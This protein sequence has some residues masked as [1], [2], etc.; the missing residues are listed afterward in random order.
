MRWFDKIVRLEDIKWLERLVRHNL[1]VGVVPTLIRRSILA[2]RERVKFFITMAVRNTVGVTET[3]TA[4]IRIVRWVVNINELLSVTEKITQFITNKVSSLLGIVERW[5][6]FATHS[7]VPPCD[8]V[9]LLDRS[10]NQLQYDP[11]PL[12][13]SNVN[14]ALTLLYD[15]SDPTKPFRI[16]F[17][18]NNPQQITHVSI[19][20]TDA[21]SNARFILERWEGGTTYTVLRTI[22]LNNQKGWLTH[23]IPDDYKNNVTNLCIRAVGGADNFI[24]IAEVRFYTAYNFFWQ[25]G[26]EWIK[27]KE[28]A[29]ALLNGVLSLFPKNIVNIVETVSAT[30]TYSGNYILA[31]VSDLVT[32]VENLLL[33]I[34][35][36]FKDTVAVTET[37]DATLLSGGGNLQWDYSVAYDQNG[38][39]ISLDL[40]PLQDSNTSTSVSIYYTPSVPSNPRRFKVGWNNP[41][42]FYEIS[43]HV[44]GY[45][46]N[47]QVVITVWD[48][49]GS[50]YTEAISITGT[51]W[52]SHYI[53]YDMVANVKEVQFAPDTNVTGYIA[54]SEVWFNE[55]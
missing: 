11:T 2:V 45:T 31:T 49:F 44:S 29:I 19:F 55:V 40:S 22:S 13:D 16:R 10:Y 27:V 8:Y 12:W 52:F 32:C 4:I 50:S 14:T 7:R 54:L 20:V 33:R 17:H 18:W 34:G 36:A 9:V 6:G 35:N 15:S 53:N 21:S 1:S 41:Q 5:K 43:F 37:V 26:S 51:G 48:S 38:N 39:Q 3:V 23:I 25:F 28:Y 46:P 30:L 47:K 24:T 42:W